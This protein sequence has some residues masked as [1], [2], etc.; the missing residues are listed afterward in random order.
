M[1]V[2]QLF[3]HME[4]MLV[5]LTQL[6]VGTV[7]AVMGTSGVM[8]VKSSSYVVSTCKRVVFVVAEATPKVTRLLIRCPRLVVKM[9]VPVVYVMAKLWSVAN[10]TGVAN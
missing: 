4:S 1:T 6:I 10:S 8:I 2:R 9:G 7:L 5:V 3:S